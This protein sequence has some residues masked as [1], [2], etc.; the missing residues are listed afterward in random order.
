MRLKKKLKYNI[1]LL[2]TIFVGKLPCSHTFLQ[3][4]NGLVQ[5]KS[6]DPKIIIDC[7]REIVK[8]CMKHHCDM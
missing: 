2:A 3:I 1:N 5:M 8:N 6:Q 4:W 7:N